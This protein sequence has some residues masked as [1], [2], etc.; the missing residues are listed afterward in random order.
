MN[1]VVRIVVGATALIV[2]VVAGTAATRTGGSSISAGNPPFGIGLKLGSALKSYSDVVA[3]PGPW[4]VWNKSTCAYEIAKTHPKNYVAVLRKVSGNPTIGYMNY[5]DTDPFGISNSKS[6]TKIAAEAGFKLDVYNLMNPSQTEPLTQARNAVLKHDLGVLE[7]N[8]IAPTIPGMLRILKG[9]CIPA[10]QM[11]L[12]WPNTPSFGTVWKQVGTVEGQWAAERV[13]ALHWNPKETALVMCIWPES[14]EDVNSQF[15]PIP[16]ELSKG[17]FQVSSKDTFRLV[18]KAPEPQKNRIA[19]TDWL[20][21]HP[22]YKH[23]IFVGDDDEATS[24]QILAAKQ[25]HVLDKVITITPGADGLGQANV[26]AG[27]QS[28]S[29]A[30][31]PERYGE[32]LVPILEDVLAGNPVP[33]LT[34]TKLIVLTKNNISK[35]YPK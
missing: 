18:C 19:M 20:T 34:S 21:S 26:R 14:G 15:I 25:A 24:G 11:Y 16:G 28:M 1:R 5:G 10:I 31:F 2:L 6:I 33:G 32:W 29:V 30:F 17:G 9:A 8:F 27:V 4:L 13:K 3:V 22:N 12:R 35:Y 23:M 7:A